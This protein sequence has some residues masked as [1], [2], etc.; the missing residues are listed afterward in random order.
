MV[1]KKQTPPPQ[2][3]L[4][5]SR[6]LDLKG[7]KMDALLSELDIFFDSIAIASMEKQMSSHVAVSDE[8]R[9]KYTDLIKRLSTPDPSVFDYL[10]KER[11]HMDVCT[12]G[13]RGR[14]NAKSEAHRL[15]L[16]GAS[17][18]S[19]LEDNRRAKCDECRAI[20]ERKKEVEDKVKAD[21]HQARHDF[22]DILYT[23]WT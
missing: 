10:P 1:F 14:T 3:P 12:K 11:A 17:L 13:I 8:W 15:G 18:L 6:R 23:L 4:P 16:E 7:V 5:P 21:N 22:I 9:E 19:F 2:P 20:E